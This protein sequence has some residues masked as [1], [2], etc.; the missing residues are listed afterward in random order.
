MDLPPRNRPLRAPLNLPPAVN[1]PTAQVPSSSRTK[2]PTFLV[3]ARGRTHSNPDL[4]K[5]IQHLQRPERSEP[6]QT[7]TVTERPSSA[8]IPPVASPYLSAS[9]WD[10]IVTISIGPSK[11]R[12]RAHA[13]ILEKIPFFN[14]CLK[15]PM[16]E[17]ENGVI[18]MPED[19]PSHVETIVDWAYTNKYDPGRGLRLAFSKVKHSG[20]IKELND[21]EDQVCQA[22]ISKISLYATAKKLGAS[23]LY[24]SV[25]QS[26]CK[27]YGQTPLTSMWS[28]MR[29][30]C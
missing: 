6:L 30:I 23:G 22:S 15:T 20:N 27:A 26:I 9:K 19:D 28:T 24:E 17:R 12:L 21:A 4:Q 18:E 7:T 10:H 11:A 3:E 2:P 8:Y 14:K 29:P 16:R 13:H 5:Y 1:D 25:L